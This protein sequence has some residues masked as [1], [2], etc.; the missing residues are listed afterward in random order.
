MICCLI[1]YI[2][3][4]QLTGR[5]GTNKILV[6]AIQ[7]AKQKPQSFIKVSGVGYYEPHEMS[8]YNEKWKQQ[9][10]TN[11]YLMNLARDWEEAGELDDESSKITRQVI[12]RSGVV[13]G[14]DG[15]LIHNL[16]PFFKIGL[17]QTYG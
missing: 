13:L 9:G 16:S 17:G 1:C 11:D 15:G 8:V 2:F 14:S 10:H 7:E 4:F 3:A 12:I 6:E 5:I